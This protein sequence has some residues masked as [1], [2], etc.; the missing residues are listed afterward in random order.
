MAS[1]AARIRPARYLLI[2][3]GVVA[4]LYSLVFFTGGKPAP[5]LGIDLQ[6]G[7]TVT[8][9]ARSPNGKAPQGDQLEQARQII[10][11]RV[12]GMGVSG[13]EVVRDGDNIVITVPGKG[14]EKA[15]TLGQTAKLNFRPVMGQP[16]P[17]GAQQP[18]QPGKAGQKQPGKG[19]KQQPG[20]SGQPSQ[21]K[22]QGRPAPQPDKQAAGGDSSAGNGSS[23]QDPKVTAAIKKAKKTRQSTNQQV[24][25]RA[26][27]QLDCRKPDPLAGNADPHKPVVACDK[28]KKLK[29]ILGPSFLDG[30]QVSN[31][32]ST[33][34]QEHGGGH[35][36]NLTFKSKGSKIWSQYTSK[37][38]G[39]Q[40]GIVLDGKVQSAP[41]IQNPIPGG[42]TQIS[43]KFT[44]AE[45]KNLAQILKYGS[46]PL[47]FESSNAETVSATLGI[48]SLK[49]GLIAGGIGLAIVFL[50]CLVYY[51]AL[52]VLTVLSLTLSIG[53]VYAVLVLLG[54]WIGYSL[55]LAGVAGM[56]ISIGITADSFVVFFERMKDE[57]REGRTFRSAVPRAW[58]R[59]RRT[60][61]SADTVTFLAAAVLYVM[62][63]GDVQGFAFTLGL[64]TILDLV[65]VF[66]VTHPLVALASRS[67]T[68]SKPR[69]SGLGAV[70]RMG[71]AARKRSAAGTNAGGAQ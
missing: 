22:P 12:N 1:P 30:Q 13:A 33:V 56:I 25:Q 67:K 46:L 51:R 44:Q 5:K 14:G 24:L 16:I 68:L 2:F 18:Q 53:L 23:G 47:S 7:T 63:A 54:R 59:A 52:G 48:A 15:K 58:A 4:L 64:S 17:A 40:T 39:K 37:N 49:A 10:E 57:I 62:A 61:L 41:Q 69:F 60:I 36:V 20:G 45:A 71:T 35:I 32:T 28:D 26:A 65:V 29:Y 27:Q 50:Y 21:P 38:V 6:G 42:N 9:T 55:D 31:A 34:D 11:T 8:L 70:Q 3:L 19:S 43:G 66:L